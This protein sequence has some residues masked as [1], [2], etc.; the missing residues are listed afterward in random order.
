MLSSV[1]SWAV[2]KNASAWKCDRNLDI[3]VSCMVIL[4]SQRNFASACATRKESSFYSF[5]TSY[6]NSISTHTIFILITSVKVRWQKVKQIECG[7]TTVHAY[8]RLLSYKTLPPLPKCITPNFIC[9]CQRNARNS[10]PLSPSWA[11]LG[12]SQ[13]RRIGLDPWTGRTIGDVL[14]VVHIGQV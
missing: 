14:M 12:V 5:Y 10:L 4:V 13:H 11:Y 8:I 7:I 3:V 6:G 1:K 9:S 2:V